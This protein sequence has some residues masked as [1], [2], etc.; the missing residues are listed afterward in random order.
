VD[1]EA[2]ARRSPSVEVS[3]IIAEDESALRDELRS[4]LAVLWPSLR[5]IATAE[6]GVDALSMFERHRPQVMFL[7]I[8]MPGLTGLEV[9][10][11]VQDRCH[12]VF[13]TAYSSHAVAAF[14]AGA[15]DYV[16]KPY[17]A[18]RLAETVRRLQGR[19]HEAPSWTIDQ[20]KAVVQSLGPRSYLT[21]IKASAGADVKLIMVTEVCYF[22]ADTKYT[23]VATA[24]QEFII[25]RTIKDLAADL[26]PSQFWQ[27]HRS[28][29]VNVAAIS[30]IGREFG[31]GMFLKLKDRP[32]RL[33]VSETHRHLFRHM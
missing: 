30:S 5:I 28:T 1:I 8:Q 24:T 18:D 25:R 11:Q 33:S 12:L 4:H 26:D 19:I 23:T 9:A 27:V 29:I 10:A 6:D 31:G 21:W 2:L 20:F 3:A 22:A 15:L 17:S 16:L 7:D 32:E 13:I 14:E